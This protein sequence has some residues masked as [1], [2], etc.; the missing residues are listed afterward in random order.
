MAVYYDADHKTY[1]CKFNYTDWTGKKR[2]TT[3]RG[4]SGKRAAEKFNS[5][6]DGRISQKVGQWLVKRKNISL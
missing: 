3:K 5:G 6:H 2:Y 1:Y 4:F